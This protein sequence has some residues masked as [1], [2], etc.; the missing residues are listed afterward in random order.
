MAAV[1]QGGQMPLQ[2]ML[3]RMRDSR[4]DPK[5]RAQMAVSAAPYVHP[6]ISSIELS[7][8]D[9]KTIEQRVVAL[10][11]DGTEPY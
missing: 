11:V 10:I 4:E 8:K 6:K 1:A 3:D 9:G 5:V 2:H 7:G